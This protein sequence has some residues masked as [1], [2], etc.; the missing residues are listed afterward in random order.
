MTKRAGT[1]LRG[2][3]VA[4]LQVVQLDSSTYSPEY[5]PA[6][7]SPPH[8][9]VTG[10]K[11]GRGKVQTPPLDRSGVDSPLDLVRR[12]IRP[13][14]ICGPPEIHAYM[15]T[16]DDEEEE[17]E[18][19]TGVASLREQLAALRLCL[20]NMAERVAVS[21]IDRMEVR[22]RVDTLRKGHLI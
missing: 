22:D 16:S 14:P 6:S 1:S 19:P 8:Y 11:V 18:E 13:P 5:T 12:H 2:A 10:A 3:Q 7:P 15:D 20:N 4:A 17:G 9:C 21:E